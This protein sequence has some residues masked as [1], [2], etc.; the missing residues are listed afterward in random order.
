MLQKYAKFAWCCQRQ[1]ISQ[2]ENTEGK[3]G[4]LNNLMIRKSKK[5][6]KRTPYRIQEQTKSMSSSKI[7]KEDEG[8]RMSLVSISL[9]MFYSRLLYNI[10]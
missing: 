3:T 5:T 9:K 2:H 7:I 1:K 8:I 10:C 6:N 4:T